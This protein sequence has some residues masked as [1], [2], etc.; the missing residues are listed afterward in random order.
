MHLLGELGIDL[1]LLIAQIINFVV[2]LWLLKRFLY[3]PIL[4]ILEERTKKIKRIEKEKE[5]IERRKIE[6]Q[7]KEEEIIKKTKEKTKEII[8]QAKEIS[9]EEKERIIKKAEEGAKLILREAREKA[10]VEIERLKEQ[11]RQEV[12]KKTQEV[13]KEV[14]SSSFNRF[15]HRKYLE[16]VIDELQ[17]TDFSS[18]KKEVVFVKAVF[19]FPP[20]EEEE[21]AISNLI[22]KKV[23]NSVFKT[24]VD[25]DL[26][27]GVKISIGED[28]FLI[29]ASLAG[30]IKNCLYEK[31]S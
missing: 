24:Q 3:Q 5:E 28:L 4:E 17:Q 1:K 22:F 16:E 29:D 21:K 15:L 8:E 30:K 6:I 2:L 11:E 10:E 31:E 18:I 25:S 20:T 19:A 27:A 7:R 26:I 12:I 14:L 13:L 23:K 9:Q